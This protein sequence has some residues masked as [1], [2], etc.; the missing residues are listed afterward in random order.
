MSCAIGTLAAV[1]WLLL[2][3]EP[4]APGFLQPICN[5][6]LGGVCI[7]VIGIAMLMGSAICWVRQSGAAVGLSLAL[8]TIMMVGAPLPFLLPHKVY[9]NALHLTLVLA[10]GSWAFFGLAH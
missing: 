4:T 8:A 9:R 10:L 6:P 2:L 3:R 1:L 5:S 7:R